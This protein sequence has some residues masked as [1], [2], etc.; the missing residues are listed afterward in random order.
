LIIIGWLLHAV[1]AMNKIQTLNEDLSTTSQTAQESKTS[2]SGAKDHLAISGL[3]IVS[4]YN[5]RQQL[6][7]RRTSFCL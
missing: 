4:G 3:K 1:V 5:K 2:L 7:V 6:R